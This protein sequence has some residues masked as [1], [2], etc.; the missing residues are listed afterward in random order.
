VESLDERA[1]ARG[2]EVLEAPHDVG[3][4]IVVGAV[5]NPSGGVVGFIVNPHFAARD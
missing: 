1:T 2:A 4:G 3:D 5:R